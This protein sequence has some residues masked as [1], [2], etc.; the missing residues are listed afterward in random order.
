MKKTEHFGWEDVYGLMGVDMDFSGAD[1]GAGEWDYL[2]SEVA[3]LPSPA[4]AKLNRAIHIQEAPVEV[5]G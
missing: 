1:E 5:E 2:D 4:R 3:E